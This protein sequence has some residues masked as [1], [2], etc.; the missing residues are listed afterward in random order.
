[1]VGQ[2]HNYYYKLL[3]FISW[4]LTDIP[5]KKKHKG[6]EERGEGKK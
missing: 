4:T 2:S 6:H 3:G 1:M 5:E